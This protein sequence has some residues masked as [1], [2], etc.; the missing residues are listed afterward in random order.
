MNRL[1][2][3]EFAGEAGAEARALIERHGAA[4]GSR[5]I[6]AHW[7]LDI[8]VRELRL[9]PRD[10]SFVPAMRD[11]DG[12]RKELDE[13]QLRDFQRFWTWYGPLECRVVQLGHLIAFFAQHSTFELR[14]GKKLVRVVHFD[15][16][17]HRP[18][19]VSLCGVGH[20][21]EQHYRRLLN[22]KRIEW[23]PRRLGWRTRRTH[24]QLNFVQ[25]MQ[26]H[27]ITFDR[28]TPP[29]WLE[30]GP[31]HAPPELERPMELPF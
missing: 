8:D 18:M 30:Y 23:L 5:Y 25:W 1:D 14:E 31:E 10:W 11:R 13:E 7:W 4:I 15:P 28:E 9:P 24:E 22:E 29:G 12:K 16:A 27:L 6:D 21:I 20:A 19:A 17:E 2:L 26:R 3:S